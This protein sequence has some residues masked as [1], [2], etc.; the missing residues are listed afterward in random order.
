LKL[1]PETALPARR[2]ARL[3]V[4]AFAHVDAAPAREDRDDRL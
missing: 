1:P 4:A 3:A 2:G